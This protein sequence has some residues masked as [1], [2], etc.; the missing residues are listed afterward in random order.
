V[1]DVADDEISGFDLD[2]PFPSPPPLPSPKPVPVFNW[3]AWGAA[4]G[5]WIHTYPAASKASSTPPLSYSDST[6]FETSLRSISP[7]CSN[8]SD[9]SFTLSSESPEAYLLSL[10]KMLQPLTEGEWEGLFEYIRKEDET[11]LQYLPNLMTHVTRH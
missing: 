11:L 1:P 10:I 4:G 8:S 9:T 5:D 3:E 7:S 6:L 2:E